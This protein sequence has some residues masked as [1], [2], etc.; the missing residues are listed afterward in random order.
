MFFISLPD[1]HPGIKPQLIL[2]SVTPLCTSPSSDVTPELLPGEELNPAK[3][4]IQMC[5]LRAGQPGSDVGCQGNE[6]QGCQACS[7]S[8][9]TFKHLTTL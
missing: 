8:L 5:V 4:W 7:L 1:S 6:I 2:T 9:S 3:E